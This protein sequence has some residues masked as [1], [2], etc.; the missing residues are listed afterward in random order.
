M[1]Y[2]P[3]LF[4]LFSVLLSIYFYYPPPTLSSDLKE[5]LNKGDFINFQDNKIFYIDSKGNGQASTLICL[6][7]FP[8][9][10]YDWKK[11][12]DGLEQKFSRVIVLDFL[13]FGFSEKP[14]THKY[15]IAEQADITLSLL[16]YLQV[17][18]VHIL[19]HDYGDTVALELLARYNK[20]GRVGE[21]IQLKSLS[22]LNGAI[23][24]E[25][26]HPRILQ[27]I[28]QYPV[29][30]PIGASVIFYQLFNKGFG[31][32]FGSNQPNAE[33]MWDFWTVLRYDNGNAALSSIIEF[34]PERKEYNERWVG[35]LKNTQLPVQMIYG[36]ADP[37]NPP[38]FIQHYRE[39]VPQ[40]EIVELEKHIGHYP[41]WEDPVNVLKTFYLFIDKLEK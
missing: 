10:S 33:E 1:S 20:D 9:S 17:T 18:E 25:T 32:I 39:T 23:F 2:I 16:S 5:W 3:T 41:H 40:H 30:G 21:N 31:E 37:V 38:K 19:S 28:L 22:M 27:K 29:I 12:M 7:G 14:I 34:L 15:K 26:H 6:H 4:V 36:P 35:A 24:L 13:G 11:V 8:S